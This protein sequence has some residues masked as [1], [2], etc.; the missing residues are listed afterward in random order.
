MTAS[1]TLHPSPSAGFDQPFEML[2]ACHERVS[3]MLALLQRLQAHLGAGL[4][5]E[6][7]R[8][9]ARDVMRYF[10][11]AAPHHH[12]DEER[13]VF[14]VLLG[15]SDEHLMALANRL[16]DDHRKMAVTWAALRPGLEALA[17]GQWAAARAEAHFA[18][19]Q[20]FMALY[21]GH[22]R[23]E[24]EQAYPAARAQLGPVDQA[25]MGEEMA[26][27]RGVH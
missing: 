3:R 14:P 23:L 9:A 4:A 25:A 2:S 24:D 7:A 11:Q 22:A 13:H 15:S 8:Q 6:P 19:W 27:R 26:K 17:Q 20:A 16:T 21:A 18:V 10:D 1:I 12:Q 5:D